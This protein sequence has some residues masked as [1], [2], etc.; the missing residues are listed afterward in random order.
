MVELKQTLFKPF[1][2]L[3]DKTIAWAGHI[4]APY[5]LALVS[6]AESSFFPIPPDVMLISMGLAKPK[7][8]WIYAFI[9]TLFSVLGGILGYAIGF[10]AIDILHPY[11]LASS[12]APS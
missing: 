12:S 6:F 2:Y 1:S 11:I 3:Y 8:A 9:V 5:Y 4:K 10:Y 7:K